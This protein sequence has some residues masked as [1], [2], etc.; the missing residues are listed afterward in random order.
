M[1]K[2]L[3]AI[4]LFFTI[5]G[6]SCE[7]PADVE[8]SPSIPTLVVDAFINNLAEDQQIILNFSQPFFDDNAYRPANGAVVTVTDDQGS[9][10]LIFNESNT[11]GVYIWETSAE[12]PVIGN[13]G[14]A[15]TLRIEFEGNVFVSTTQLNRTTEVENIWFF[16][17]SVPFNSD[18]T[19]FQ[20]RVDARDQVGFGDSYWIKTFWN[21]QFLGRPSEVNLAF[22]SGLSAGNP[23]DGQDFILPI[24]AGINPVGEG[25]AYEIGD[26]IR[27]E[28]HSIA[29]D[30]FDYFVN[31]QIQT[32]RPGGF[33][34]LFAQPLANLRTNI[35]EETDPE[36]RV[37]GYFSVSAISSMEV[38][39]TEDLIV[40]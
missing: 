27:V 7:S 37:L 35:Q 9:A 30:T 2:R 26:R 18:S 40:E 31:L 10:P 22:D 19:F 36:I 38:V 24:R 39:F 4:L 11:P 21:G 3:L 6:W 17:E 13:I 14:D 5:V 33:A 28:I 1:M 20:A 32:D 15:F 34:E 25:E 29:N 23:L 16:E 12:R 8:L